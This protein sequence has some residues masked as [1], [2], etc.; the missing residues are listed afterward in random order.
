MTG[1]F[2]RARDT[3]GVAGAA[4]CVFCLP[5]CSAWLHRYAHSTSGVKLLARL[6]PVP[7]F[8]CLFC[9]VPFDVHR[10]HPP[11]SSSRHQP[12]AH[13][14]PPPSPGPCQPAPQQQQQ[15]TSDVLPPEVGQLF[16]QFFDF[17]GGLER[18]L[19]AGGSGR[20]HGGGCSAG[21]VGRLEPHLPEHHS[22]TVEVD[23][24]RRGGAG[25]GG[26]VLGRMLRWRS[27]QSPGSAA[28]AAAAAEQ[29]A[30]KP[31]AGGG[32]G[33]SKLLARHDLPTLD[34]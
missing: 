6:G 31:G 11:S 10:P 5:P 15:Q 13:L 25:Y 16:D 19:A 29:Q 9:S 34:V 8:L 26:G 32:R 12:H 21:G 14:A 18:E 30:A 20:R 2:H 22:V 1:A 17:A 27:Q 33:E 7:H 23:A 3:R 4:S 28:E 24:D